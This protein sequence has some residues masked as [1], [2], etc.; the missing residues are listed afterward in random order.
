M[1]MAS[2]NEMDQLAAIE[3]YVGQKGHSND[4]Q[5]DKKEESA[6]FDTKN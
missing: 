1:P 2:R 3:R 4:L 6:N 5:E